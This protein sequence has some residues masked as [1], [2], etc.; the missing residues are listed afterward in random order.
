M[1]DD[2]TL[3]SV[4]DTFSAAQ[5]LLFSNLVFGKRPAPDGTVTLDGPVDNPL[6]AIAAE[7]A[8]LHGVRE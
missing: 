3:P 4:Q 8:E 1:N 2:E 6:P 5:D 7:M